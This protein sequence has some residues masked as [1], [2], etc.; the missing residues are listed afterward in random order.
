MLNLTCFVKVLFFHPQCDAKFVVLFIF[1]RKLSPNMEFVL[2]HALIGNV[3][4]QVTSERSDGC[5]W[6]CKSE[7]IFDKDC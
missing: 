3:S 1:K 5:T 6:I 7:A 2:A 4:F